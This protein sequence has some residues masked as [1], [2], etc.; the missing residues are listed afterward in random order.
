[1]AHR[2]RTCCS[3]L[4]HW[5]HAPSPVLDSAVAYRVLTISGVILLVAVSFLLWYFRD[6]VLIRPAFRCHRSCEK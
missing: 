6:M 4:L 1:M 3:S 5:D 2:S